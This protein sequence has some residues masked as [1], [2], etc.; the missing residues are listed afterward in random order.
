MSVQH[1]FLTCF[2]V[3]CVLCRF[4]T[5]F[6]PTLMF[7]GN[8]CA[9]LIFAKFHRFA[10]E[11]CNFCVG[12]S[13]FALGWDGMTRRSLGRVPGAVRNTSATSPQHL[14]NTPGS[15]HAGKHVPGLPMPSCFVFASS[16]CVHAH[17]ICSCNY[18]FLVDPIRNVV[19]SMFAR[20]CSGLPFASSEV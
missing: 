2:V 7:H 18:W 14:R 1:C 3:L 19:C 20:S 13:L 4:A 6:S 9:L 17:F 12:N 5:D 16:R 10:S 8:T 15:S 11:L